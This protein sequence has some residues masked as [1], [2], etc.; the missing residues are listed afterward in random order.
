MPVSLEHRERVLAFQ[1]GQHSSK[2]EVAAAFLDALADR[3]D[4]W[5]DESRNGW[6]THQVSSNIAAA[7]DCRRMA[8]YLRRGR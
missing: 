2:I 1:E 6:S 4:S 7:N 3:L 5:A 8:S